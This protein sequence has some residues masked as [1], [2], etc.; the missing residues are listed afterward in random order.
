M[1]F[2]WARSEAICWAVVDKPQ[3]AWDDVATVRE[4]RVGVGAFRVSI[5]AIRAC[6]YTWN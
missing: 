4:V 6:I 3:S 2:D 1:D 5:E